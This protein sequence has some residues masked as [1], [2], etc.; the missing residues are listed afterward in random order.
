MGAKVVSPNRR[1]INKVRSDPVKTTG[2]EWETGK[3]SQENRSAEINR[4]KNEAS[5]HQLRKQCQK[6]KLCLHVSGLK[7]LQTIRHDYKIALNLIDR[8][9][10]QHSL[11]QGT[12]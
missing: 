11:F 3:E 9:T 1:R 12:S 10:N 5:F 6:S 7:P 8:V 4:E 2:H